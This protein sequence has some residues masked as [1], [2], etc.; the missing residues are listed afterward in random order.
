MS[1]NVEKDESGMITNPIDA[2]DFA[3]NLCHSFK[4]SYK[5]Q[6][7]LEGDIN[8]LISAKNVQKVAK[9]LEDM[10]NGMNG[11]MED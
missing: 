9:V 11:L 10:F 3:Y 4:F 8:L 2:E 1:K 7:N 6:S 5:F